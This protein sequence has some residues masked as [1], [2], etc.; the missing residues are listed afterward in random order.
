MVFAAGPPETKFDVIVPAHDEEKGIAATVESLLAADYPADMRRVIV[1]ADNCRDQ[2]AARALEA[3]A[4]IVERSDPSKRG[5]G[6]ALAYGFAR[7]LADGVAGAIVVVDADTTV[8]PNLLRAFDARLRKGA[9]AVQA[10]Y[11][12]ANRTASWRTRLMHLGFTLFHD[13]RSRAREAMGLSAGL[14]GNGMAF[15]VALLRQVPHDA[16]SLVEDVEY[17]LAIGLA[18]HRV[19]YAEEA[20]VYGQMVASEEASRSQRDRWE[21]GRMALARRRAGELLSAGI[22]RRDPVLIDLAAD[23]L[24]PPLT[25]VALTVFAGVAVVL[26]RAMLGFGAWWVIAPWAVALLGLIVYVARGV[27]LAGAGPRV[28]FDL[29][30]IPVYIIWKVARALRPSRSTA[31]QGDEWV[32]TAR[33]GEKP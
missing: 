31:S 4:M 9:R 1:V 8:T 21:G 12:V 3:G 22:T 7:S 27:W 14:R 26:A 2:T 11:A 32:R 30:W 5:K 24:V 13:V 16:V 18:G 15:A 17:G 19:F 20:T 28:I 10:T 33:E 29:M 6:Y 23:L 25:I